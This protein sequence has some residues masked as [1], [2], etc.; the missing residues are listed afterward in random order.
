[1]KKLVLLLALLT[2]GTLSA[3][4]GVS[5]GGSLLKGFGRPKPWGGLHVMVEVPRDDQTSYFGRITHH[6]KQYSP[7]STSATIIAR[8]ITNT[9]PTTQSIGA[10]SSM[11]YTILEGGVRYYLG[12]GYDFG[13]AGYGGTTMML[14]FNGVK[15]DYSDFDQGLYELD[16]GYG[17]K[18]SI[19]SFAFGLA[20]GVKYTAPGVGTFYFDTNLAY[21]VYGIPSNETALYGSNGLYTQLLFN[22]NLGFRKDILW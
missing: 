1:M 3:Q 10:I 11:N 16:Q 12:N 2:S 19:V 15:T 5:G 13:W 22:F 8:D 20:G 14:I 9:F 7:D 6:F 21:I 18:G 4:I 17:R